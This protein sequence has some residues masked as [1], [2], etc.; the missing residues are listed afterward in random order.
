LHIGRKGRDLRS[1]CFVE[2][3]HPPSHAQKYISFLRYWQGGTTAVEGQQGHPSR[4]LFS[5]LGYI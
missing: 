1:N 5:R 3:V 4:W 2:D